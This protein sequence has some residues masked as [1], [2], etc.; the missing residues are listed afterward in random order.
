[1]SLTIYKYEIKTADRITINMPRKAQILHIES[2]GGIIACMWALVNPKNEYE[3]RTFYIY[4]TGHQIAK[5]D[6][7][8]LKYLGTYQLFNGTFVGH[9]FEKIRMT[10][11]EYA[12]HE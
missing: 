2:Q 3:K 1:M 7:R 4:G 12:K 9:L 8:D 5:C 10:S 11:N 6:E